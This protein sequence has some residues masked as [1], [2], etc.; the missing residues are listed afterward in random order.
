M[1]VTMFF[2]AAVDWAFPPLADHG[3]GLAAG[4]FVGVPAGAG[5]F[6]WYSN[7]AKDA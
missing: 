1:T 5:V 4:V 6:A 7:G 2:G 3:I